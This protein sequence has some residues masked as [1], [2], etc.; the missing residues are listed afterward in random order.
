MGLWF[1][2]MRNHVDI[3][4]RKKHTTVCQDLR[5]FDREEHEISLESVVKIKKNYRLI[6][7]INKIYYHIIGL[8]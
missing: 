4:E 5:Q 7:S 8:Q 6:T 3:V 1:A 2:E